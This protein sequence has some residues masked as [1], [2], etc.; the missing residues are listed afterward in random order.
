MTITSLTERYFQEK[1]ALEAALVSW[2]TRLARAA[3]KI[4]SAAIV[5][6]RVKTYRSFLGK[7]YRKTG[8]TRTWEQFGD[9][10]ALKAVFPTTRGVEKF[11]EW[12]LS[13]SQWNPDL[14]EKPGTPRELKYQAKQFD[15][16]AGDIVDSQG[17]AIPIEVQVRTAASDAWYVVDHRLQYKG[18]VELTSE[19]QRKL[20]R[21]IVLTELFD[22][23]VEAVI[24]RQASM[25]E[26]GVARLYESLLKLA[27]QLFDD[28]TRTSRPEGLLEL[29]LSSY[30]EGELDTLGEAI[31]TFVEAHKAEL[32]PLVQRHHYGSNAFVEERDWIYYEPEV[33]LIAERAMRRPALFKS[34]IA[35]SDF[36]AVVEPMISEFA[37]IPRS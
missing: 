28:H 4:D 37:S 10:V 29:V 15:M 26:Y 12:L 35:G 27:E 5:S 3:R 14:D 8:S 34:T 30:G 16:A 6:G 13:Q 23:E 17:V 33:L 32:V 36:Q 1:Q 22:E 18:V 7:A 24:D 21:L 19:L 31:E 9:L 11:T 20:N 2:E 25:P